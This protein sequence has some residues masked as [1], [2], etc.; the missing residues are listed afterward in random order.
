VTEVKS[1]FAPTA[2]ETALQV[3]SFEYVWRTI[4]DKYW[5]PEMGGLDWQAVHDEL[6]PRIESAGNS[7]EAREVLREMIARLGKSHFSIIPASYYGELRRTKP[8]RGEGESVTQEGSSESET[9]EEVG[10]SG[11]GGLPGLELRVVDHQPLVVSVEPGSP[12]EAS[13][14]TPGWI[15]LKV[16]GVM[17]AP[18]IRQTVATYEDST[19]LQHYSV[20]TLESLVEGRV[21]SSLTMEFLDGSNQIRELSVERTVP[22][23]HIAPFGNF[24][25][26]RLWFESKKLEGRIGYLAFSAFLD[27]VY[28]MK[29]F[30]DAVRS[31]MDSDGVIL[32]LRGNPGG[33]GSMAI[34]MAGWFLDQP[35][36]C[37]GTMYMRNST[38]RFVVNPRSE[39][40][41]GPVAVLVDGCTVST[42]EILAGG[43]QDIGRARIFGTRTAGAALPS[44]VERLPNGD[45]FQYAVAR[46]VS[47][48]GG[49][50][51]GVGLTPD[52]EVDMERAALLQGKDPVLEA[53]I[54]WMRAEQ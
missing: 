5:D 8:T 16:S 51:E 14:V 20:E 35:D 34:G 40:F 24:P 3:E 9:S 28:L 21:G 41:R 18:L 52:V 53:A 11:V 47:V 13:G 22:R 42:A 31:F 29:A 48:G 23:G 39:I 17:V 4:R 33:I 12:A 1:P 26:L 45:G 38:F 43:L 2:E 44:L 10:G 6:R 49:E 25:G 15:L 27:P 54:A 30:E 37:L 36:L 32:D 19:L 46:Y 7:E 50:L